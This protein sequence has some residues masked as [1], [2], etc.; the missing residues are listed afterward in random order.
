MRYEESAALAYEAI[1]LGRTLD[2]K[3]AWYPFACALRFIVTAGTATLTGDETTRR[4]ADEQLQHLEG[5][6]SSAHPFMAG[7]CW[8]MIAMA[9]AGFGKTAEA[10]VALEEADARYPDDLMSRTNKAM[11]NGILAG[12]LH[13]EGRF[14]E[15]LAAAERAADGRHLWRVLSGSTDRGYDVLRGAMKILALAS[16]GRWSEA[17]E[18][19]VDLTAGAEETTVSGAGSSVCSC[20]AS[21]AW[22]RS[23]AERAARLFGYTETFGG[24]RPWAQAFHQLYRSKVR[25]ALGHETFKRLLAEGSKMSQREAI[26]YGI[27]GI[28]P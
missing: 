25:E 3:P 28:D 11:G 23:D 16:V 2:E 24:L 6:I 12:L 8:Q 22:L 15:S 26:A 5:L 19:A 17:K 20:L 27:E 10:I 13:V 14:D 9:H 7:Y 1:R 4:Y 21:V 18:F